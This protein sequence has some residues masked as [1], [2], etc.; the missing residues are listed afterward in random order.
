MRNKVVALS[1]LL[2][3]GGLFLWTF[4]PPLSQATYDQ[5]TIIEKTVSPDDRFVLTIYL[6]GGVLLK[7][8][9]S[10]IAVLED[11]QTGEEKNV[12]WLPPDRFTLEWLDE[13]TILINGTAITLPDGFMDFR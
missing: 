11:R 5:E 13:E 3:V 6:T 9:Y 8:D 2:L 4:F 12:L 7:W 1:V 10:Y